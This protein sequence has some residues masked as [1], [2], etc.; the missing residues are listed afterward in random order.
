[1]QKIEKDY[2]ISQ[3][4]YQTWATGLS[5]PD[6][7]VSRWLNEGLVAGLTPNTKEGRVG[8]AREMGMVYSFV[9]PKLTEDQLAKVLSDEGRGYRFMEELNPDEIAEK[10]GMYAERVLK[11][12]NFMLELGVIR[13]L[14]E[15]EKR[16]RENGYKNPIPPLVI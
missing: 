5:I 8:L 15:W 7:D 2:G 1:M 11:L 10:T 13:S 9:E 12:V 4:E 3:D 14:N 6:S 16:R